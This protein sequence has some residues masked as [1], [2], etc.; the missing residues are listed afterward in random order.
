MLHLKFHSIFFFPL[1]G[2]ELVKL[3]VATCFRFNLL[4]LISILNL[5]FYFEFLLNSI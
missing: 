1:G 5:Y 3:P 4:F 2:R